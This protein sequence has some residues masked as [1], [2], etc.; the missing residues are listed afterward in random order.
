[1]D[2]MIYRNDPIAEEN[3][4]PDGHPAKNDLEEWSEEV[5]ERTD[6]GYKDQEVKSAKERKKRIRE[7]DEIIKKD[8]E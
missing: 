8:L 5:S 6:T 2:D 3:L 4:N 7:M 1:M